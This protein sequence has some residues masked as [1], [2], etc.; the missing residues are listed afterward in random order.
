METKIN[1]QNIVSLLGIES[2]PDEEKLKIIDKVTSLV[3]KRLLVRIY[4]SLQADKQEE[5]GKLLES[6]NSQALSDFLEQNV[7][8]L[9]EMMD[10]ELSQ[11]KAE[12]GDWSENI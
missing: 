4:D 3:Q 1:Q 8:N 2:L 10:L 11:V 6:E 7:P 5:F 12:L 9:Q